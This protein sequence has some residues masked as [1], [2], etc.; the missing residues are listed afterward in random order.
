MVDEERMKD[1]VCA[2]CFL[3]VFDVVGQMTGG[4]SGW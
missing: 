2:L 1:W 3:E 4:T